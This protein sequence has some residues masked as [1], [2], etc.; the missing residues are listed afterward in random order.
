M[1]S[2]AIA[3]V[4]E[5][6]V[7]DL[8]PAQARCV[9]LHIIEGWTEGRIASEYECNQVSVHQCLWGQ[10]GKRAVKSKH[11]SRIAMVFQAESGSGAVSKLSRSIKD[12]PV[13]QS[14]IKQAE[15][16][17]APAARDLSGWF[18]PCRFR[19]E[20]FCAY[21]TMILLDN[22]VDATGRISTTE[23]SMQMPPAIVS[24]VLPQLRAFGMID[25]NVEPG[26]VRVLKMPGNRPTRTSML[27]T[28]SP[29]A[30]CVAGDE[31]Q[32]S[33]DSIIERLDAEAKEQG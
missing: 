8:S 27:S 10:D 17:D 14:I 33:E 22:L 19:P 13:L 31:F 11:T 29:S 21:A 1:T 12:D 20:Y 28:S 25:N 7:R 32:S 16:P 15:P 6:A 26:V 9:I 30:T 5:L 2:P 24:V 23:L 3:R 18:E 4:I